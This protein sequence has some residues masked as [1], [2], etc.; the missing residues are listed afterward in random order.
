MPGIDPFTG[1]QLPAEFPPGTNPWSGTPI[2]GLP[3]AAALT[4]A[5]LVPILQDGQTVAALMSNIQVGG[6]GG[7]GMVNPIVPVGA[8]NIAVSRA[9][10]GTSASLI[11]AARV[12]IAGVGRVNVTLQN[13]DI[14]VCLGNSDVTTSSG[15]RIAPGEAVTVPTT[16][17]I[18]G[19]TASGTSVIDV[20]EAF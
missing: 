10:A 14:E 4:G 7:G 12:G 13:T 18:Y 9:T 1:L 8:A 17:A 16:A 6:G 20:L 3:I 19:I 15:W 5:E 2:S 11:V